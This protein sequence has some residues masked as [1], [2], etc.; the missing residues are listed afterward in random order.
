MPGTYEGSIDESPRASRGSATQPEV[1]NR[2]ARRG[3]RFPVLHARGRMGHHAQVRWCRIV[4]SF[5]R[6]Y[7]ASAQISGGPPLLSS[8]Y[9]QGCQNMHETRAQEQHTP[10]RAEPPCAC[11][12]RISQA[13]AAGDAR[14]AQL[15]AAGAPDEAAARQRLRV[16]RL[17]ARQAARQ[18]PERTPPIPIQPPPDLHAAA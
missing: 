12:S 15:L 17:E 8:S 14:L 5:W 2:P 16:H 11:V 3:S 9:V 4:Q 7:V 13:A 6:V 18:P 1:T 10:A